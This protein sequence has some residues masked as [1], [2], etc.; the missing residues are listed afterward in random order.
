MR[1][2]L[3]A[4]CAAA[5]LLWPGWAGGPAARAAGP[6][7]APAASTAPAPSSPG[8][9]AADAAVELQ[10]TPEATW[11]ANLQ[12][13]RK[14]LESLSDQ[15]VRRDRESASRMLRLVSIVFEKF[16]EASGRATL[17]RKVAS[18]FASL[19]G[20]GGGRPYL[21]Q[22]VEAF[23][24]QTLL[25]AEALDAML[26]RLVNDKYDRPREAPE[27]A[28][29]LE[30][31]S[32]RLIALHRAGELA[33]THPA[34]E[35]AW[36]TR[37]MLRVADRRYWDAAQAVAEM[38]R[39]FG[40]VSWLCS[41]EAELFLAA[42]RREEALRL[43]QDLGQKPSGEEISYRAR[44]L[45]KI[46]GPT[47]PDF[48]RDLGLE[49]KW[50]ALRNRL[51][52]A[53]TASV[54]ALLDESASGSGIMPWEGSRSA[55]VW[56]LADRL[57]LGQAPGVLAPLR[58]AEARDAEE[59]LE[60]ARGTGD[61]QAMFSLA[62]RLPWAASVQ[63][64]MIVTGEACLRR[65]WSGLALRTFEDVLAHSDNAE[66]RAKALVGVWLA[67]LNETRDASALR[68][69][70]AGAAPDTL[71]PWMGGRQKASEIQKRLLDGVAAAPATP[72]AHPA[73][74]ADL[75]C[76]PPT[77]PWD[78]GIFHVADEVLRALPSPLGSIQATDG[79]IVVAGP[80]LLACFGEDP[81]RPLWTRSPRAMDRPVRRI[82][83]EVRG[84]GSRIITAPA[85]GPF[86]PAVAAGRIFARWGMDYTGQYL[87][88]L[89]AVDARS[90][91]ILWST[92]DDPAWAEML[93]V[94]DPAVCDGRVYVLTMQEKFGPMMPIALACLSAESGRLLWHRPLGT[95]NLAL[96]RSEERR[97]AA[98]EPVHYG[99]AVT[100]QGGAV[101][102]V[103]NLGFVARCDARDGMLEW[104]APYPRAAATTGVAALLRRQGAP[105]AVLDGHVVCLPRD[106]NGLFALDA[107]TGKSVW[108]VPLLP[109]EEAVGAAEN[110]IVVKDDRHLVA[111]DAASGH[112]LWD[113]TVEEGFTSQP[114]LAGGFVYA[115]TPAR[116]LRIDAAT[117]ILAEEKPH[118]ARGP[119]A[120][121][122]ERGGRIVGLSET[123]AA[124]AP[125]PAPA[126]SAAGPPL[127]LPL[128]EAWRLVRSD[129]ELLTP[130]PGTKT[131]DKLY[132]MSRG[133]IE[134]LE[135]SERGSPL[136]H[137]F[138]GPG[139]QTTLWAEDMLILV[140]DKRLAALDAATGQPRWQSETPFA[141]A[142]WFVC[143]PFVLAVS[144]TMGAQAPTFALADLATGRRLWTREVETGHRQ[145]RVAC[146]AYDGQNLHLLGD[147]SAPGAARG[148]DAVVRPADG[149]TVSVTP[150][151]AADEGRLLAALVDGAAGYCLSDKGNL[152]EFPPAGG[153]APRRIA[154]LADI[155]P[156]LDFTI[157]ATGPW[158]QI[159]QVAGRA[160]ITSK[161]WVLRRD[162][163]AAPV[164]ADQAGEI[165]QNCLY[166]AFAHG[167]AG[168][169]LE[170]RKAT[171]YEIPSGPNAVS[172]R[173]V[174]GFRRMK[175]RL[176]IVSRLVAGRESASGREPAT[177]SIEVNTFDAATATPLQTQTLT[178]I[179]PARSTST[180]RDAQEREE[181]ILQ[182]AWDVG[183]GPDAV[184]LADARG[185]YA[186]AAAGPDAP[187]DGRLCL[188]GEA[189]K[190]VTIDGLL[191]EWE[192][193]DTVVAAATVGGREGRLYLAHDDAHLYVAVRY[194]TAGLVPRIG[195]CDT[196]GGNRLELGLVT[197][198]DSYR[199]T[200]GADARGRA[201]WE[202]MA[203]GSPTTPLRGAVRYDAAAKELT[204]EAALPLGELET[205]GRTNGRDE[206]H[207]ALS[208]TAW[209]EAA[210]AGPVRIFS[211][212]RQAG[213]RGLP[214]AASQ[215]LYL[216]PMTSRAAAAMRTI[217]D[218][219]PELPESFEYF[220]KS[221]DIKTESGDA[222]LA[223]YADF[224]K[225]HAAGI[226]LQRLLAMDRL[227]RT[228][229]G[230]RPDQRLL[231]MAAKAGV[232]PDVCSRYATEAQAYL[233]QWMFV[234]AGLQPRSIVLEVD[235]GILPGPPGW[236]HRVAWNKPVLPAARPVYVSPERLPSDA[237]IETRTPLVLLGMNGVP[238]WG[239]SFG[240]QGGPRV[241]WDRSAIVYGGKEEVFLDDALPEGSKATGP[242]EWTD[243]PVKS[244]A[245]AHFGDVPPE[246][247]EVVYH[248]VTDF[249]RP[250]MAHVQ[251]PG[252]PYISQWV[253]LDAKTPPKTLLLGLADGQGWRCHAIW[254]ARTL[255]GRY[256]GPLPSPG[257]WVELRLPLA[258]TGMANDPIHG[259]AF[260]Q[261]GGRVWWGR[262][263]VVAGG[264]EQAVIDGALPPPPGHFPRLW[265]PWAD[266]YVG[267][268]HPA[269]GKVGMGLDCDGSTGYFEAPHS[270]A[271]E[272]E[273]LTIEAWFYL[274]AG[275]WHPDSRRWVV[276]KNGNEETDGHYGLV[277]NKEGV[278]AYLNIGGTKANLFEAWS[279][280]NVL[281]WG[282][283][284]H[285][286]MTYDSKDLKVY[287]NGKCLATKAV[288]RKRTA[289]TTP[290]NICRRQDGYTYLA[291]G[292]DEV[293]L[294]KRALS[295]E[296]IA[297]RY[298]TEGAAPTGAPA[299]ALVAHW[300]FDQD[301]VP[302]DPAVAWQW[303]E[304]PGRDGKPSH[305]Q[306][307][308]AGYGGHVCF[309]KAPVLGHL[310]YDKDHALAVLARETPALGPSEEAW[311]LFT[312]ML[313]MKP[314]DEGHA[315]L[316]RWFVLANPEHPK[317][318]EALRLLG[319]TYHDL[320]RANPAADV[321]AVIAEAK[322][323]V[324]TVFSYH[325][326]YA[327][328]TRGYVTAWQMIGPFPSPAGHGQDTPYPP[329]TEG[330]RLDASYDGAGGRV[331]WKLVQSEESH[332]DLT[333]VF[334]PSEFV[335]AYAACWVHTDRPRAVVLEMAADDQSK[336]WLNRQQ[337]FDSTAK[338][339]AGQWLHAI[340]VQLPA[341]WSELL[342]KIGNYEK[343]W[344][345]HLEILD[346][347]GTGPPK[348]VETSAT[349]PP[350]E[351]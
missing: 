146:A 278:G 158:L 61:L 338:G 351:K 170:T 32:A 48:P 223:E 257:Q 169:D 321:E 149:T 275:P 283:W 90:G 294:Y 94:S 189:P 343:N 123:S 310:P 118:D 25:A 98:I 225:N 186:M 53:D 101:Y 303:A 336:M 38:R 298:R 57:L 240:Q 24:G 69:A 316:Y 125:P 319:E 70:F 219:L 68:A 334:D 292:V 97:A 39:L 89:V 78:L 323:P 245:K 124:A 22:L 121:M 160:R 233:S 250:V 175:D 181:S 289:G 306:A 286:A 15:P 276:S 152:W 4:A 322:L 75:V 31:A 105:P 348:G 188:V 154:T 221:A 76:L 206:Q 252:G 46:G 47:P 345:F 210:G 331:Q 196:G 178:R 58:K 215:P 193:G 92:D 202:A 112:V 51:G 253:Y 238:L 295:E 249:A 60:R 237:W 312:R 104:A 195:A 27:D 83:P 285:I 266:G 211:W 35:R 350:K 115:S 2:R 232:P 144:S 349:P 244:G 302:A 30:Y 192:D 187:P 41:Q 128:R 29:W 156:R 16:P 17:C 136:W 243:N 82:K 247:Y 273:E 36:R 182:T 74:A 301:A 198:N 299:A 241:L 52:G 139:F 20:E 165:L 28:D 267:G 297:E 309:L 263:A 204:Y 258:W 7:A 113:R 251:P 106:Y 171:A 59:S 161:Q 265:F 209:E 71:L 91:R 120:A 268:A 270:P 117:G 142:S 339:H 145:F 281:P 261:D 42:G 197:A 304:S 45:S 67:T 77:P 287:A 135:M 200:L 344:G 212:G 262:T 102:A 140:Y 12:R 327:T 21:R 346:P 231:G 34:L 184:Y 333:K 96:G 3:T 228:Q 341:G 138:L 269:A 72:A 300:G 236:D 308:P 179:Q 324:E 73:L 127:D 234:E 229:Y 271:L 305:M 88:G 111:V 328:F 176:W 279:E 137:R 110:A 114:L 129:A 214:P 220:L 93:P 40:D 166:Y 183:W 325:R 317:A 108:N 150:F 155:N 132:L 23:P 100:V 330:V 224:L 199:W 280:P 33:D 201:V 260:G 148:V 95:Q 208:V 141:A 284:S 282:K 180:R 226:T 347:T 342:V 65:G 37:C 19:G 326:R 6:A 116:M 64:A 320:G 173:D 43:F 151:P 167:V 227:Y 205:S 18:D 5:I 50:S 99:N 272:P 274:K 162:N 318:L 329:E 55:S 239:I 296:E 254:G 174:L 313:R 107:A 13:L 49:M 291:A 235:D 213:A 153:K 290:L 218:Q 203:T 163:P 9:P 207:V 26:A 54:Q 172:S 86:V 8:A 293:R 217:V 230:G 157:Q 87:R 340:T 103:T 56:V 335:V 177:V 1:C 248:W 134:C 133:M 80:N 185:L 164:V 255:H 84:P 190:P 264:K 332:T 147:V 44:Q 11:D 314:T 288:N 131:A 109:T 259:V 85:P 126:P 315:E 194:K 222:L 246:R 81:S 256:V 191:Q 216:S 62:R 242:W 277:F 143:P 311:D 119:L 79:T 307:P 337:V 66:T 10:E 130:P 159:R 122:A 168:I 63:E 14:D